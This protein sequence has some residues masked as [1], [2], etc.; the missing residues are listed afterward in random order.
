MIEKIKKKIDENKQD[1][2]SYQKYIKSFC[3]SQKANELFE[4]NPDFKNLKETFDQKKK[5]K[6]EDEYF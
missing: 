2:S 4:N 3:D 5:V 6:K 1:K